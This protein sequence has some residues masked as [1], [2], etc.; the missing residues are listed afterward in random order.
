M[1]ILAV[2]VVAFLVLRTT[3]V[4]AGKHPADVA[5]AQLAAAFDA[6]DRATI[7]KSILDPWSGS[8]F[9]ESWDDASWKAAARA[10]R[11]AR[12]KSSKPDERVYGV[13]LRERPKDVTMT[14]RDHRWLLDYSSFM[15]PFPTR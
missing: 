12:L 3:R 5:L 10:L 4:L 15:G 1:R 8:R 2:A 14:R 9:T 11:S 7:D 6:K 13:E